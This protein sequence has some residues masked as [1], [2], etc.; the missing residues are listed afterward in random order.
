MINIVTNPTVI[1]NFK[2]SRYFRQNLGL[3]ATVD[4]NG[5]RIPNE[6]D[7]FS[8]YYSA[9]YKTIIYGQGNIGDIKFYIDHYIKDNSFGVYS[10]D[11]FEEFV[12]KFDESLFKEKGVDF[13][14]GHIL[15]RVEEE[16][17]ERVKKEELKKLEVKPDGDADM[18]TKNPGAVSY[19]DLKAYLS[20]K[21]KERYNEIK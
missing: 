15:K 9:Q 11:N 2:K 3:A 14:I 8:F 5:K 4:K 1:N 12:F 18:I 13:Y 21:Q 10:G 19:A 6:K 7:G 16:Y 17:D 20:K